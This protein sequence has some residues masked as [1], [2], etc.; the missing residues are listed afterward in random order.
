MASATSRT[1][2]VAQA[3]FLQGAPCSPF[4]EL[5]TLLS[6]KAPGRAI[7]A[8]AVGENTRQAAKILRKFV[9]VSCVDQRKLVEMGDD[10]NRRNG[11]APFA[12]RIV[13]AVLVAAILSILLLLASQF[14]G[15]TT[16]SMY[17]HRVPKIEGATGIKNGQRN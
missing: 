16:R 5:A 8:S 10:W 15:L 4:R 9:L 13:V 12:N 6:S 11:F 14:V 1:M 2:S 3:R 7:V 17:T